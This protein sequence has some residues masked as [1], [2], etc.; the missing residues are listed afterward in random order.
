MKK[1]FFKLHTWKRM[2]LTILMKKTLLNNTHEKY[3]F[4][5]KTWKMTFLNYEQV[6]FWTT[7]MKKD[8]LELRT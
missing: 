2:F 5:L 4:K 6:F 8:V 3:I 1:D 7:H